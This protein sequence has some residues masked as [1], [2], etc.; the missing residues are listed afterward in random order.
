MRVALRHAAILPTL[1]LGARILGHVARTVSPLAL[2]PESSRPQRP[3]A[4]FLQTS[5]A[6]KIASGALDEPMRLIDLEHVAPWGE[7]EETEKVESIGSTRVAFNKDQLI[8]TRLRP[9]LQK[10]LLLSGDAAIGSPDQLRPSLLFFILQTDRFK[11]LT[12]LLTSGKEHPRITA[13]ILDRMEI[14]WLPLEE[15]DRLL[16]EIDPMHARAQELMQHSED[17][18]AVLGPYFKERFGLDPSEIR[19]SHEEKIT[20]LPLNQVAESRDVRFSFK[21]H[22]PSVRRAREMLN[23][24]STFPLSQYLSTK[25]VLG[26]GVSPDDYEQGS[27][28]HYFSMVAVKRRRV[29]TDGLN[30]VSSQYF[31]DHSEKHISVGDVLIARSGEGT[32]GKCGVVREPVSATLSDFMIRVRTD[33]NKLKAEFLYYCL[34]SP[35]YQHLIFGEKKGLG[36]NTN[37]FP[38]QIDTFPVIDLTLNEQS[39]VCSELDSC[40]AKFDSDIKEAASLRCQIEQRLTAALG[41]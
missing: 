3:L 11:A 24:R 12:Q 2:F 1:P 21:Y 17:L 5:T 40:V 35:F 16:N 20:A 6:T 26:D 38:N 27:G 39:D 19:S 34:S 29:S 9:Y 33:P 23:E 31:E 10:S 18:G 4:S 14:P 25:T 15:Q 22:A 36:N 32:I 28:H 30:H 13:D 37:I 8:T 41:A 7:V